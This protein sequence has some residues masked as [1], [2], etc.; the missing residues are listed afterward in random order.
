M[1]NADKKLVTHPAT[2]RETGSAMDLVKGCASLFRKTETQEAST[3]PPKEAQDKK[4]DSSKSSLP[5]KSQPWYTSPRI[6]GII[7]I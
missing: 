1:V 2:L 5:Q 7:R 3:S 4:P 6:V